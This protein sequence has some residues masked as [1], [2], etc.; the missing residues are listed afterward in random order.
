MKTSFV[1]V[2]LHDGRHAVSRVMLQ[3]FR[4]QMDKEKAPLDLDCCQ[5]VKEQDFFNVYVP[6]VEVMASTLDHNADVTV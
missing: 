4:V 2:E 1:V 6:S 5:L 3:K